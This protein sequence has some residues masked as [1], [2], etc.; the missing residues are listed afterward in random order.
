MKA[1]ACTLLLALGMPT[2]AFAGVLKDKL[3]FEYPVNDGA[4]GCS[5]PPQV[6]SAFTCEG[7]ETAGGVCSFNL[8]AS[9]YR[10][11]FQVALA[12]GATAKGV[13]PFEYRYGAMT[14][15]AKAPSFVTGYECKQG[16]GRLSCD[17]CLDVLGGIC[18]HVDVTIVPESEVKE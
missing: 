8:G 14:C 6:T 4:F 17:V 3:P 9:R 7:S 18:A 11:T 13:R 16:S 2:V 15:R 10:A 1:V 5:V 12:G